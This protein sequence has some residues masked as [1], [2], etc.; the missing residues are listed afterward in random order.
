[1]LDEGTLHRVEPPVRPAQMLHR[2]HMRPV[3]R[4]RE[5]DAGVEPAIGHALA[6]QAADQNRAGA[7]IAFRAPFLRSG[8]AAAEAQESSSVSS[9][10]T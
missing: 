4:C 9:G 3:E 5:G 8:Q 7:A 2:H 1:M 6:F 10:R